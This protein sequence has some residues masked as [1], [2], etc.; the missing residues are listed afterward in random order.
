MAKQQEAT[1]LSGSIDSMR[2]DVVKALE[3][4]R[5]VVGLESAVL[6]HG[7]PAPSNLEAARR[8]ERAVRSEGAVPA[9]VGVLS[10]RVV[11]GLSG[12][13]LETLAAAGP[14]AAAKASA[15]DLAPLVA[16]GGTAGTTVAA[17]VFVAGRAGVSVVATGGIGGVHRT[18]GTDLDVSADLA[19]L[20]RTP[21][22]VVCS[23]PK[24]V[25]DLPRT[26]EALEALGVAVVGYGTGRLPVFWSLDS[27]LPLEHR[28]EDA[29]GAAA[30]IEAW[31]GLGHPGGLAFAVPPPAGEALDGD[32]VEEWV[33]RAVEEAAERGIAG[34]AV[35]PY[36]L[37]RVTA[38]SGGRAL[39]ANL[40]LLE[41]NARVAA[42][43]ARAI[44]ARRDERGV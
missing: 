38:L 43:V 22:A 2:P 31:R 10:G 21:V 17:T 30:V 13:E 7:L 39:A 16:A 1:E 41:R 15:R 26:L 28:V 44:A 23:G 29:E 11:L 32:R 42:R 14:E 37:E 25:L 24:S 9:T 34:K 40:A 19:E 36:L 33:A 27:G 18:T 3:E 20:A 12:R 35:T 8:M 5:A 6:T 4:R